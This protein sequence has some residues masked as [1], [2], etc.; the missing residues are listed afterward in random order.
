FYFSTETHS[1][2][3][4][5]TVQSKSSPDRA[6]EFSVVTL[7]D[8]EQIDSYNS[9]STET[10]GTRTPK[11]DWLRKMKESEWKE[12]TDKMNSAGLELNNILKIQMKVFRHEESALIVLMFEDDNSDCLYALY[13][14]DG[15]TL[16][17]R[18]GCEG[19]ESSDGSVSVINYINEYGYDGEDFIS[20]NW[21]LKKWSASVNQAKE[22]EEWNGGKGQNLDQK[23]E[24]C[25]AWLKIYLQYKP[26]DIR[27]LPPGVQVFVKIPETSSTNLTLTC[28]VTGFYPKDVVVSLRKFTTSLPEHLQ[29][30]SGV[31]PNEDGTYQLRKSVEIQEDH[32]ADY[33]CYVNHISL[34][35][36]VITK[37][38]LFWILFRLDPLQT[39]LDMS[40]LKQGDTPGTA[41]GESTNGQSGGVNVGLTVGVIVVVVVILAA[42]GMV[43]YIRWRTCPSGKSARRSNNLIIVVQGPRWL[44]GSFGDA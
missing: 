32:L 38:V 9:I 35:R 12:S 43:I 5:Y 26:P 11:Q 1:L 37:L 42:V 44:P 28:L 29:T 30:S 24:E 33:D 22:M 8:D 4:L 23:H 18:I 19:G 14:S 16:Q 2:S 6:Y 25:E 13:I 34:Y 36:P 15:H 17:W 7:L 41:G 31:R 21:A 10:G 3:Y 39:G 40:W 20:Y 27:L